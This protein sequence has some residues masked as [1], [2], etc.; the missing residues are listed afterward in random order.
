MTFWALNVC[1]V[2][3][4]FQ[5]YSLDSLP[6]TRSSGRQ[7]PSAFMCVCVCVLYLVQNSLQLEDI[8]YIQTPDNKCSLENVCI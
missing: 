3:K 1:T 6:L 5:Q 8:Q 7:T 2:S 4:A